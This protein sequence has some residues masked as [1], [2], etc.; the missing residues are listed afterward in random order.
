MAER[1][2]GVF[3]QRI[4][5]KILQ[6]EASGDH[7]LIKAFSHG[8]RNPRRLKHPNIAQLVDGGIWADGSPY[9]AMEYV[10]ASA[11]TTGANSATAPCRPV[12]DRWSMSVLRYS[13]PRRT[14]RAPRPETGQHRGRCP[15]L[16]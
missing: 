7:E 8:T 14:D 2:D 16:W 4:A 12:G 10:E 9:L 13:G 3:Q 5:I 15:R 11:S 1:I 6:A